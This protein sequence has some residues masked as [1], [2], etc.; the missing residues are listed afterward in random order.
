MRNLEVK[1]ASLSIC[2]VVA[3]LM[4][5]PSVDPG[6][7]SWSTVPGDSRSV[8]ASSATSMYLKM[9]EGWGGRGMGGGGM[10]GG[11]GEGV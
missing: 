5:R 6:G 10:E 9:G 8:S 11:G 1:S 3:F 7:S 2:A 4:Q